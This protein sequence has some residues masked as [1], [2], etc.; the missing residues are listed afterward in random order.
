L[1]PFDDDGIIP[2]FG[3]GDASTGDKAVFPFRS[4]VNII[5]NHRWIASVCRIACPCKITARKNRTHN[6]NQ[7]GVFIIDTHIYYV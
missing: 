7:L 4:E 6:F 2:T 1:E 3:F 5:L